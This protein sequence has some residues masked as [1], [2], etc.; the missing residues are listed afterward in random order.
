M[1]QVFDNG[2]PADCLHH[3]V[4]PCWSRSKFETFGEANTY[5]NKWLGF[6]RAI[7]I[8]LNLD[9]DWDYSG[10]GDMI[11]IRIVE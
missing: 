3:D 6:D 9:E 10:Y 5:A 1:Y 8:I 7:G 4:A 11:C 2:K